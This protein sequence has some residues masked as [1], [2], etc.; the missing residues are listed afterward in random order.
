MTLDDLD[1]VIHEE[2][3]KF[4]AIM[5]AE[6]NDVGTPV[7]SSRASMVAEPPG[8]VSVERF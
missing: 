4:M 7:G 8:S 2:E 5:N 6:A 3:A 1:K